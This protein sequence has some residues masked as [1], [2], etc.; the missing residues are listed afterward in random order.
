MWDSKKY[1]FLFNSL[2]WNWIF[3]SHSTA[4]STLKSPSHICRGTCNTVSAS[5]SA[6]NFPCSPPRPLRASSSSG[7]RYLKCTP[8]RSRSMFR[9]SALC[10][11][12][13]KNGITGTWW[14]IVKDLQLYSQTCNT[15][16]IAN[17]CF[18]FVCPQWFDI[19]RK[20]TKQSITINT[21]F[22]K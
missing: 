19:R 8:S 3:P 11:Q 2:A 15:S 4:A 6:S 7:F 12:R 10:C 21:L 20:K 22:Y 17:L 16:H 13:G 1:L 18:V 5:C 14:I 9:S